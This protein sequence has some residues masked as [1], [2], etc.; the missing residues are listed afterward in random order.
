MGIGLI[1]SL[2]GIYLLVVLWRSARITLK[3]KTILSAL[4]LILHFVVPLGLGSAVGLVIIYFAI[5]LHGEKI[6]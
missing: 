3:A 4:W 5:R 6:R 2:V 1:L